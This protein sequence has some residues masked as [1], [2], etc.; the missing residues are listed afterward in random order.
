M[1]AK[2]IV[3]GVLFAV[4]LSAGSFIYI[5]NTAVEKAENTTVIEEK[6]TNSPNKQAPIKQAPKKVFD[7]YSNSLYELPLTAIVDIS[8]MPLELKKEVDSLLEKAQGFYLLKYYEN[9]KKVFIILQNSISSIDTFS[10]HNLE[11]V[12][13]SI[14][15]DNE[16]RKTV[17]SPAFKGDVD[18]INNVS[19]GLYPQNESWEMD[20]SSEIIK[21]LK[22]N[23]YDE[24]GKIKFSEFWNYDD[25]KEVKYQIKN[26]SKKVISIL[27]EYSQGEMGLRKEHLFYDNEGQLILSLTINYEGA[28]ITRVMYYDSHNIEESISVFTEYSDGLKTKEEIYDNNYRLLKTINSEYIDTERLKIQVLNPDSEII[29]EISN[30]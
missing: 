18:E 10:R 24:K 22:H 16:I 19:C 6:Q 14:N 8:L 15:D 2:K 13:L 5:L 3:V 30:N 17:F 20:K 26:S 27:K 23:V 12:E 29:K 1:V 4:L 7:L 11:F 25:K 28:N 21:P 9:E